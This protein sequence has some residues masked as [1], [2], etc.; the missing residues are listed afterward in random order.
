MAVCPKVGPV[1]NVAAIAAAMTGCF[2]DWN[3]S[4]C[5]ANGAAYPAAPSPCDPNHGYCWRCGAGAGLAGAGLAGAG[6]RGGSTV[7]LTL[8]SG[9]RATLLCR[10]GAPNMKYAPTS[11]ATT[12]APTMKY[13]LPPPLGGPDVTWMS[14][15]GS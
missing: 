14:V 7:T 2:I 8:R 9:A 10:P 6:A 15:F 3:R 12:N 11:T 13:R 5:L 4:C 1:T